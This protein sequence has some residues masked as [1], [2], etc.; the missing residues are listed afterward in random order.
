MKLGE[1]S[2]KPLYSRGAYHILRIT[3]ERVPDVPFTSLRD[4]TQALVRVEQKAGAL[5][6]LQREWLKTH[7]VVR[8]RGAPEPTEAWLESPRRSGQ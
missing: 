7:P 6:E 3:E 4:K 8:Y 5:R 1:H 2:S